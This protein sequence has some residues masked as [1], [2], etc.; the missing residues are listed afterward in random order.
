VGLATC[1]YNPQ[2]ELGQCGQSWALKDDGSVTHNGEE[3]HK[4]S[5]SLDEGDVIVSQYV[6]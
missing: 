2:G 4:T 6:I 5:I 3:K 1:N